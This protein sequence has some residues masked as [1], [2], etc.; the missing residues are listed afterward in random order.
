MSLRTS[1]RRSRHAVGKLELRASMTLT[2]IL[3]HFTTDKDAIQFVKHNPYYIG[4]IEALGLEVD[5]RAT[6]IEGLIKPSKL[7]NAYSAMHKEMT[8]N[9]PLIRR[10]IKSLQRKYKGKAKGL[11]NI[12]PPARIMNGSQHGGA[13]LIVNFIGSLL[14]LISLGYSGLGAVKEYETKSAVAVSS[15]GL[16][17]AAGKALVHVATGALHAV[18]VVGTAMNLASSAQG[19]LSDWMTS[20]SNIPDAARPLLIKAEM[21]AGTRIR[22]QLAAIT[23]AQNKIQEERSVYSQYAEKHENITVV[24]SERNED[25]Q[26]VEVRLQPFKGIATQPAKAAARLAELP[27]IRERQKHLIEEKEAETA[28]QL[29]GVQATEKSVGQTVMI[30]WTGTQENVTKQKGRYNAAYNDEM[31]A[32]ALN[33][34][35]ATEQANLNATL[36]R[37]AQFPMALPF[38][39]FLEPAEVGKAISEAVKRKL[40]DVAFDVAELPISETSMTSGAIPAIKEKI[41]GIIAS[42]EALD[43]VKDLPPKLRTAI[44][45]YIRDSLMNGLYRK[46]LNNLLAQKEELDAQLANLAQDI[47]FDN[48]MDLIKAV[49]DEAERRG[50]DLTPE[51]NQQLLNMMTDM[52]KL[53]MKPRDVKA[54]A[55]LMVNLFAGKQKIRMIPEADIPSLLESVH[56][57]QSD[58]FQR[59]FWEFL[60]CFSYTG[61]PV[62]VIW[63]HLMRSLNQVSS[64]GTGLT[65]EDVER[66]SQRQAH[67]LLANIRESAPPAVA[68]LTNQPSVQQQLAQTQQMLMLMIANQVAQGAQAGVLPAAAAVG[69]PAGGLRLGNAAAAAAP[70]RARSR[71]GSPAAAAVR[72]ADLDLGGGSRQTRRAGGR[73]QT[74]RRRRA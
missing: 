10:L 13:R 45:R 21:S 74:Q 12:V 70:A 63:S 23:A 19:A 16:G 34:S 5:T 40:E 11:F 27:T 58:Q 49:T 65:L 55:K 44:V 2:G 31:A 67:R 6:T 72:A 20:F 14:L 32:R 42:V 36:I 48:D 60:V 61:L 18:P 4:F 33:A 22:S 17:F 56:V 47:D 50:L 71:S 35:Y 59:A 15:H 68:A 53:N 52:T 1:T 38:L 9:I 26:L 3:A 43:V 62:V 25:G 24:Y 64:A 54:M 39:E 29:T 37:Q 46:R 69:A 7:L 30:F 41:D 51:H 28:L 66:V 8:G 73:R 57:S